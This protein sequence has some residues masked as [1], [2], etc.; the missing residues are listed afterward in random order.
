MKSHRAITQR[1][2]GYL[3]GELPASERQ[4]VE[5]HL[6]SCEG[7][8]AELQSLRESLELL[9]KDARKPSEHRSQ[10]YWQHFAEKVEARIQTGTAEEQSPSLV[11]RLLDLLEENRKP[12]G[13]G[14][15]S[16]L[17]LILILFGIWSLWL[18][19]PQTEQIASD[20]SRGTA[21][22]PAAN[23]QKAALEARA[24]D[25]LEQSKV[26]LI[27]LLNADPKS[28]S[29]SRLFIRRDKEVSRI[30]VRQSEELSS[31]LNDP[32]QRRLK[33]LISDLGL[34]LVQIANIEADHDVQGIE[35]VKSGVEHNG[36]LFK[37]NLE[38]IQRMSKSVP[39]TKIENPAKPII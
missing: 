29:D 27:G 37:I 39:H 23:V 24:G 30:L 12:F 13:I 38:Q 10:L 6:R 28:L 11:A 22:E 18:R 5:S 7:C 31:E 19:G 33:E 34:I 4:S 14:F 15:A 3:K 35:I 17:S 26:L 1:L 20:A 16:A 25:Y 9:D 8:A 21:T 32:S 36:I 2:Y